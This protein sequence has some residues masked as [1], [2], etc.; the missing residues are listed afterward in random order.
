MLRAVLLD[1]DGTLVDSNDA[2]AKAWVDAFAEFGHSVAFER[3]R[4]LIGMG[5][6]KLMPEVVAID[7]ESPAGKP[8]SKRRSDIFRERYLPNLKP[9]PRVKEL[10]ERMR[11]DGLALVIA[12]SAKKQELEPLLEICG[13][14]KLVTGKVTSDDAEES[15][16]DGDIVA[17]AL[18][19]GVVAA[20]EALMLG[21]TPYD[22]EA[23]ERVHVG[24][25]ALRSG[26][27]DDA[28]LSHAL[29]IYTDVSDLL[30]RYNESPLARGRRAGG[31]T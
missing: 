7:A 2:H 31:R 29:A 30:A 1:V 19:R 4:P 18:A 24:T 21:D 27:W 10:L 28:A 23:A 8:I 17:A 14:S 12:T 22:V 25:V 9:F 26:G 16:P 6:D 5:G 13:A 11:S 15:K 3:V 20:N